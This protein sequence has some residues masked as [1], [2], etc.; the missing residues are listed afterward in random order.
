MNEEMST[1]S[2]LWVWN[3]KGKNGDTLN[4]R[5]SSLSIQYS[6]TSTKTRSKAN[7]AI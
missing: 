3:F 6:L 7:V 5:N 4:P 2:K 1:E